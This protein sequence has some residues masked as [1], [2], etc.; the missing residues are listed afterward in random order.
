[1]TN[2][3]YRLIIIHPKI[4]YNVKS[5]KLSLVYKKQLPGPDQSQQLFIIL[6]LL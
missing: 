3:V 2:E 6:S 1:M 4:G 5:T